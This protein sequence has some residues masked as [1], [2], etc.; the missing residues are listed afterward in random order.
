MIRHNIERD[1]AGDQSGM[2]R[3]I[4]N[5]I[6]AVLRAVGD[7]IILQMPDLGNQITGQMNRIHRLRGKR[8][9]RGTADAR[10]LDSCFTLMTCG[11]RHRRWLANNAHGWLYRRCGKHVDQRAYS[12]TANFLVIRQSQMQGCLQG[13]LQMSLRRNAGA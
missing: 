1:T 4:G 10:H 2:K 13:G 5:I 11:D 9:M 6:S 7:H 3:R 8:R 12:D